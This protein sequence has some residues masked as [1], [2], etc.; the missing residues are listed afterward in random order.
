MPSCSDNLNEYFYAVFTERY[1]ALGN[2]DKDEKERMRKMID[3]S[4][5]E[6]LESFIVDTIESYENIS[7]NLMSAMLGSIDYD[8]LYKEL[9]E[10]EDDLDDKEE[11]EA[12]LPMGTPCKKCDT[13]TFAFDGICFACDDT[14]AQI[15]MTKE[16]INEWLSGFSS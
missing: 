5:Y 1:E 2:D 16:H 9:K 8:T 14:K 7:K 6:G 3:A 4:N 13:R 10:W 15:P 11:E 12:P